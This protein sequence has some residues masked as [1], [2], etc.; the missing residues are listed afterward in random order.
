[1]LDKLAAGG[2]F[3]LLSL[4]KFILGIEKKFQLSV[5]SQSYFSLNIKRILTMYMCN[6][7]Y[8][9]SYKIGFSVIPFYFCLALLKLY[10]FTNI[11]CGTKGFIL[12]TLNGFHYMNLLQKADRKQEKLS[13]LSLLISENLIKLY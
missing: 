2:F 1:M 4:T 6:I 9:G 13:L 5:P 8:C 12:I 11:T 10:Y 3:Y 7:S